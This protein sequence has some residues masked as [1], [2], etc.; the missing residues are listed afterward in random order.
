MEDIQRRIILYSMSVSITF[1]GSREGRPGRRR[2][3]FTIGTES[4]TVNQHSSPDQ[5]RMGSVRLHE[6]TP[7]C[8]SRGRRRQAAWSPWSRFS[9]FNQAKVRS[10]GRFDRVEKCNYLQYVCNVQK[11]KG[12]IG[13]CRLTR[14]GMSF[15]P[16]TSD[17]PVFAID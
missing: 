14:R 5:V 15:S 4:I 9:R 6:Y 2:R 13:S 17:L 12:E 8:A 1:S 11:S 10:G 3:R 16:H 7:Y